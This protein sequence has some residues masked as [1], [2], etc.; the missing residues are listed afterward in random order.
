M[1]G[2]GSSSV[3]HIL[4]GHGSGGVLKSKIRNWLNGIQKRGQ[5]VKTSKP[6]AAS[7]GGDAFTQVELR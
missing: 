6:A 2:G 4:H 7:D 5:I 3:A 1:G